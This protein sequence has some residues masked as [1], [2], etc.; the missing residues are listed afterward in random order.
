MQLFKVIE[1]EEII[2]RIL[3]RGEHVADY[4][5]QIIVRFYLFREWE[6]CEIVLATLG[7]VDKGQIEELGIM[8]NEI[9]GMK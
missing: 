2:S 4:T 3:S 9:K 1:R 6:N 8:Y 7:N 5:L